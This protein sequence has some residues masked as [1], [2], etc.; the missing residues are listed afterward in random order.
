MEMSE[1]VAA[2]SASVICRVEWVDTDASGH[3]HHGTVIRWVEAAEAAMF[4]QIGRMELFGNNPRVH[5]EVD[6]RSR[7]FFGDEVELRLTIDRVGRSSLEMSFQALTADGLV[8]S[9]QV[10]EV[11]AAGVDGRAEPWSEGLR[12][13]LV[14]LIPQHRPDPR[15]QPDGAAAPLTKYVD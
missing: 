7:A 11:N 15:Q 14:S 10:V 1:P 8:A 3:Y 2:C 6:Y 5:Y 12:A 4:R 9:G 13:A